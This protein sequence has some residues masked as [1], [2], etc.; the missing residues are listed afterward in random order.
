ME[1]IT[2][3]LVVAVL[4]LLCIVAGQWLLIWRLIDRLLWSKSIPSLGPVRSTSPTP[5]P[6]PEQMRREPIMTFQVPD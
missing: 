5:A 2:L 1:T 6:A 4:G 3:I